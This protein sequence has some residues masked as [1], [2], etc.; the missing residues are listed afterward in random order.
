MGGWRVTGNVDGIVRWDEREFLVSEGEGGRR[1]LFEDR[2]VSLQ[3]R[4]LR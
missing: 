3:R 2:Q 1:V 4:E